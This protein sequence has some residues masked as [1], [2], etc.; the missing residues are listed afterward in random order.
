MR[1][2]IIARNLAGHAWRLSANG[3]RHAWR[4]RWD[5]PRRW[6]K[7]LRRSWHRLGAPKCKCH[8]C[9]GLLLP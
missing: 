6:R 5:G 4:A 3:I 2:L 8:F 7:E 1:A 9:K